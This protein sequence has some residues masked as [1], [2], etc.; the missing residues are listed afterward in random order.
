MFVA[1][2]WSKLTRVVKSPMGDRAMVFYKKAFLT[3]GTVHFAEVVAFYQSILEQEPLPYS[4]GRYAQFQLLGMVLAIFSPHP[5]QALEFSASERSGFSLCLE[6]ADLPTAI[7]KIAR[8]YA[9]IKEQ[10]II[11]ASHGRE[12]YL[13]DPAG[14]RIILHESC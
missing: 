7:A 4:P 11:Y 8:F 14:N 6:V 10:T 13:Y 12:I 5:D 1:G 2:I 9:P 3:I